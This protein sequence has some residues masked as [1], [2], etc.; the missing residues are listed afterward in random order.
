M[1][2]TSEKM[3]VQISPA[4][5]RMLLDA[6]DYEFECE[7][8]RDDSGEL[9]VELKGKGRQYTYW[10]NSAR[11]QSSLQN[12][13]MLSEIAEANLETIKRGEEYA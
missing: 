3:R 4:T 5:Q 10:V 13:E 7:E 8:R 9:G 2:Q 11:E 6:P 1:E 12:T